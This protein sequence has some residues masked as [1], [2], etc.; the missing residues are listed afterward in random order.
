MP[1]LPHVKSGII[2]VPTSKDCCE[3]RIC[4]HVKARCKHY[5]NV[6]Y[7]Y[8][9]YV[10]PNSLIVPRV[11]TMFAQLKYYLLEDWDHILNISDVP[12]MAPNIHSIGKN[13]PTRYKLLYWMNKEVLKHRPV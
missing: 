12:P 6:S 2:T 10:T 9:L 5:I 8:V 1:Q 7:H 11:Y 3:S 4:L 13:K